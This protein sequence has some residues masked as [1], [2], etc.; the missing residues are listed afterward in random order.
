ML[1]SGSRLRL[2]NVRLTFSA[3]HEG[4]THSF[5]YGL[6][7]GK[8]ILTEFECGELVAEF[9]VDENSV[10]SMFLIRAGKLKETSLQC[11]R[12]GEPRALHLRNIL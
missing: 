12:D 2:H 10:G 11:V 8:R 7:D 9:E 6:E 5:K 1:E 3:D 4:E